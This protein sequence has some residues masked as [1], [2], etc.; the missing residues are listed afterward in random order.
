MEG[1]AVECISRDEVLL[2]LNEI[3]IGK[4]PIPSDVPLELITASCDIQM[5]AEICQKILDEFGMLVEL[6][7]SIVA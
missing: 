6:A 1:N 7:L 3:K 4:A 2:A 5:M